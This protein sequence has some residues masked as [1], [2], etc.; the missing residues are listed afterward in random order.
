MENPTY[1]INSLLQLLPHRYPFLLVDRVTELTKD[2][3][4][5]G[6][7]NITVN[8]PQ[9]TG[10]FPNNPIMPGVLLIEAL[11]Q[12]SGLL[13]LLS[14]DKVPNDIIIFLSGINNSRFR[15]QVI[16]G[17]QVSLHAELIRHKLSN[18]RFNT[19]ATVNDKRVCEAEISIFASLA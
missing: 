15:R 13:L 8:E 11:A 9:F 16:P 19:Y 3:S 2:K 12:T 4:I 6:I 5:I 1:D 18:Y 10:H 17:D 7:K 14:Q